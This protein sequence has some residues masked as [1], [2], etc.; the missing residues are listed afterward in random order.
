MSESNFTDKTVVIT[1]GGRGLGLGLA[2]RFG[3]AGAQVVIAEIDGRRGK[4]AAQIL[5]EAGYSVSYEALDVRVPAQSVALVDKVIKERGH[6]DVWVNNAGLAHIGPAENLP[7]EQW[8]ES[9]A[10]LLSGTFYCSQAVGRQ[11]LAQGQGVIV[12][13]ASVDGFKAIEERVAYCTAKA[14]VVMLTQAL[15]I[16]WAKRGVRVVAVA[17]GPILTEL[18]QQVIADG[19]ASVEMYV[20]RTPLHKLGTVE[21]VADAVLFLASDEASYI[22]AETLRV[23][24]GWVAYQLF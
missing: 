21:D 5:Q 20:K 10:V 4:Q 15:G 17:P 16:E 11:M 8:D 22:T 19:K 3:E 24:G 23:D 1:G 2:R 14:G 9:I 13:L 6:I 7:I 12:N 18:V